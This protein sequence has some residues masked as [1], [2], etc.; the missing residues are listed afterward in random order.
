MGV[1]TWTVL[2]LSVLPMALGQ[3]MIRMVGE[4]GQVRT[5]SVEGGVMVSSCPLR[6]PV[7]PPPPP[8]EPPPSAPPT[9]PPPACAG[10]MHDVGN[11]NGPQCWTF[12]DKTISSQSCNALCALSGKTL[13][14]GVMPH[15]GYGLCEAARATGSIAAHWGTNTNQNGQWLSILCCGAHSGPWGATGNSIATSDANYANGDCSMAC[16]CS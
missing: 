3:S 5:F 15:T 16:V 12:T 9:T 14:T 7:M 4:D 1:P 11:G 10:V 2:C 13:N 6:E 8:T